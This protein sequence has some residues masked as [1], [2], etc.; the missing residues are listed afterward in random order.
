MQ[1]DD[2]GP[3]R[4]L[5]F[6]AIFPKIAYVSE[7]IQYINIQVAEAEKRYYNHGDS[8]FSFLP[9]VSFPL[10]LSP[11]LFFF[12]LFFSL[13]FFHLFAGIPKETK[14]NYESNYETLNTPEGFFSPKGVPRADKRRNSPSSQL[15]YLWLDNDRGETKYATDDALG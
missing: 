11:C 3:T 2:N 6:C 7:S 10:S 14:S 5:A 9:L 13:L 12:S 8:S 4:A 15:K 1:I